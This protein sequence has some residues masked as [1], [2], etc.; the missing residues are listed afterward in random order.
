MQ[1]IIYFNLG[2][3]FLTMEQY[4]SAFHYLLTSIKY[5]QENAQAYMFLGICLKELNDNVNSY[6]AFSKATQLDPDN[7]MIF[8][9]FAIFLA[10]SGP[11]KHELAK[12]NFMKHQE[13][14]RKNNSDPNKFE[15]DAQRNALAD[16]L[17]ISV[18]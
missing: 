13:I 18:N 6:N 5:N 7:H 16:I 2:L 9:N 11:D 15:I 17:G 3:V 8:L 14:Y 12:E 4:S 10:E 1:P